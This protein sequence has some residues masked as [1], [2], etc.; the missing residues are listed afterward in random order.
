MLW[1]IRLNL[2][3]RLHIRT[4]LHLNFTFPTLL[5]KSSWKRFAACLSPVEGRESPGYKGPISS[6]MSLPWPV[7]VC[8]TVLYSVFCCKLFAEWLSWRW[9]MVWS[10][11]D[12]FH[13]AAARQA[14]ES[15]ETKYSPSLVCLF[16]FL[17]SQRG[18]CVLKGALWYKSRCPFET[19]IAPGEWTLWDGHL[20]WECLCIPLWAN[21]AEGHKD[22]VWTG[23]S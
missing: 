23:L 6:R 3:P 15:T 16:D 18:K 9:L 1:W 21:M 5:L 11:P 8:S 7:T 10:F 12:S 14:T 19:H 22:G 4:H 2:N 17:L 13:P 20:E